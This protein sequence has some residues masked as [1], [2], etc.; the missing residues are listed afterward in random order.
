M[1]DKKYALSSTAGDMLQVYSSKCHEREPRE[2]RGDKGVPFYS[3]IVPVAAGVW[4]IFNPN[5]L[6]G[7]FWRDIF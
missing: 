5:P 2:P 3:N 1:A 7:H 4:N 6:R